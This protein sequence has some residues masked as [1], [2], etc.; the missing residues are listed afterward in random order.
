MTELK[1]AAEIERSRARQAAARAA[2]AE[3]LAGRATAAATEADRQRAAAQ[4]E[5][6]QQLAALR[7]AAGELDA[8]R[9]ARRQAE[10]EAA[11]C[12]KQLQTASSKHARSKASWRREME[13][14]EQQLAAVQAAGEVALQQKEAELRQEVG[15][16]W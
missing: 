8:E 10:A 2:D 11:D 9:A 6:A 16:Q 14:L 7:Q 12:T 15:K 3:E 4:Q 13:R 5:A 1:K